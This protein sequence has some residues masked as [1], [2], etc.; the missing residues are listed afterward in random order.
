MGAY[1]DLVRDTVEAV[2]EPGRPM[3]LADI[4]SEAARRL[5]TAFQSSP[6]IGTALFVVVLRSDPARFVEVAPGVWM[7]RGDGPEAGVHSRRPRPPLAG[8]AAAEAPVPEPACDLDAVGGPG[9]R[10]NPSSCRRAF[11][12]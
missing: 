7:H 11:A 4:A 3:S 12:G 1:E 2:L 5:G 9:A 10:V 8:G 6:V